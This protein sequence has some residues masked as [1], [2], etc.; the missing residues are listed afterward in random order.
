MRHILLHIIVTITLIPVVYSQ[1]NKIV[2]AD[3]QFQDYAFIDAIGTY[4]KVVKEG[5]RSPELFQ[6]L[7]DSYYFTGEY[8]QAAKYYKELFKDEKNPK[9][10][11]FYRYSL[12]LKSIGDFKNADKLMDSFI[13]QN[14]QDKRGRIYAQNSDYLNLI[15]EN[16]GRYEI[17][18]IELNSDY[19]EYA[20]S[21][22]GKNLVFT[23]NRPVKG[24]KKS[25]IDKWSNEPFSNLYISNTEISGNLAQAK[26]FSESLNSEFHQSSAVYTKDGKV[27]YFTA[28]TY[29]E[30]KGKKDGVKTLVLLKATLN[31]NGIWTDI[32]ELELNQKGSNNAHPALSHDEKTLYFSSDRQGSYGESDLYKAT[33]R[34]DGSFGIPE[35]LGPGINTEGRETF[36]F[37]SDANELYF[38][39][40]GYPG[41]GGLDIYRTLINNDGT[42][43]QPV[44]IGKPVNSIDD[45]FS[46]IINSATK[47][48]FFASNKKDKFGSDNIYKIKEISSLGEDAG[49]NKPLTGT[50]KEVNTNQPIIGAKIT[51]YD[52]QYNKILETQSGEGGTYIL[53]KLGY[54]AYRLKVEM[55]GYE[56]MEFY[57]TV[58]ATEPVNLNLQQSLV[59]NYTNITPGTSLNEILNT[60]DLF[61]EF[62]EY[63]LNDLAEADL[64]KVLMFMKKYPKIKVN[65]EA[66]TDARGS[67]DYNLKLS[68]KRADVVVKWLAKNGIVKKRLRPVGYGEN[69]IINQC[70]DGVECNEKEH[71]Q[72]RR[73]DFI[74]IN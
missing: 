54:G 18:I 34:P 12:C 15:D 64:A 46:F 61:F 55:P 56:T 71:R 73:I 60:H 30:K 53:G 49:Q 43:T 25:K 39:S 57:T 26:L 70:K 45:D 63:D 67:I 37:V 17:K 28:N 40:N 1:N 22:F 10:E 68:T 16:S 33:I 42:Y 4:E 31:E 13:E 3:S 66:H 58:S 48:G 65:I 14:S 62:N 2:R 24:N 59:K 21:F 44:N 23:S 50:I 36:P 7:A 69:K 19:S 52:N 27:M 8:A 32:K 38:S 72:N 51:L 29:G 11:Y 47:D 35:N 74:V 9:S 20:P 5:Y 41:L 6:R